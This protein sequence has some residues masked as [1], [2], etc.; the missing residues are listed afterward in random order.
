[1]TASQRTS[2]QLGQLFGAAVP[3]R[4]Q[5]LAVAGL[6]I[7]SRAVAEGD[8]FI[9]LPGSQGHGIQ[10]AAAA[11]RQGAVA[12]LYAPHPS[13]VALT[14]TEVPTIAVDDLARLTGIA[15]ARMAGEPASRLQVAAVTGTNGKTTVSR[16]IA[17]ATRHCA[18]SGTL[19]Y[20]FP[21]S[22]TQ[23]ALTTPDALT[24]QQ[25][26]A[27]MVDAGA[28]HLAM[29]VSSHALVQQRVAGMQFDTAVFTNLTRDHLDYHQ[30]MT[31]YFDA[32]ATLF[33]WPG[34]R[35]RICNIDD[36]YGLTL[37]QRFDN[38]LTVGRDLSRNPDLAITAIE[39]QAAG[40][41][42]RLRWRDEE[43]TIESSLL[44]DFNAT[45]LAL[46]A[47][48]MLGWE[49]DLQTACVALGR[50]RAVPG[51]M[52]VFGGHGKPLVVVDYAHTP[53]ALEN[54]LRATREHCRGRL[55]V[56]F[57]CGGER[58]RGKRA[59]MGRVAVATADRVVVTDDNPR[60]EDR[61]Q[62][63]DD[64]LDGTGSGEHISAQP[65]RREAIAATIAAAAPGDVVLLAGKGHED[66]QL[67]GGQRLALSDRDQALRLVGPSHE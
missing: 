53:D 26:L 6:A 63:I 58:D 46:A 12:I 38:V 62:I 3:A 48:V 37:A 45:N 47:A 1:M 36:D 34:L 52:E 24:L 18:L 43:T 15:A 56:V 33:E 41:R 2:W 8:V 4:W 19:G 7:D 25:R 51:R 14:A 13:L 32:K 5:A 67:I 20:G 54:A 40:M 49:Q 66:Y 42:V 21:D 9:A 22:L 23:S 30:T 57:G 59:V 35:R 55:W 27:Q 17:G 60:N 50:V 31:A 39:A 10:H 16:L 28:T 65:G 29:E 44:G 11:A 61:Q 64:I